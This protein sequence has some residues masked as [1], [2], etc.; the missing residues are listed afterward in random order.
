VA[1]SD[2][3]V[4]ASTD[5]FRNQAKYGKVVVVDHGGGVQTMYAH[6]N[7]RSVEVGQSVS[8][9][10]MIGEAGETGIATGPHLHFELWRNGKQ[11]NPDVMLPDLDNY[12]T[13]AALARIRKARS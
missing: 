1:C 13:K 10:Q 2:G 9:G 3:K 12:A 8:A 11:I 4:I 7:Q 5:L 6:L